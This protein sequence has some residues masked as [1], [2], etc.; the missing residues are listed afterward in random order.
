MLRVEALHIQAGKM[1]LRD[2]TFTVEDGCYFVLLGASG[3]G[4]TL[5][6]EA[7]AGLQPIKAGR[8]AWNDKDLTRARIQHRGMGL[9]YQEQ[10]LFPHLTVRQ[11][12]AYGAVGSPDETR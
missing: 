3:A 11:N 8:I 1:C 6:L 4:K 9:V 10:A 7:L 5:L 12:I 2:I